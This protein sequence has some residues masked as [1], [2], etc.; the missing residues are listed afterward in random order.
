MTGSY[1]FNNTGNIQSSATQR[2]NFF[3]GD[4]VQFYDEGS[5]QTSNNFNHRFSA[6][7]EYAIDS[8]NSLILSPRLS[9]QDNRSGSIL[10]AITSLS[11][12]ALLNQAENDFRSDNRG[13]SFANELLFRHQFGKTGRTFSVAVNT[14]FSDRNGGN[15]LRAENQFF[16]PDSLLIVDQQ[17]ATVSGSYTLAA[18]LTYTEPLGR[19]SLLEF[20]YNPSYSRSRSGRETEAFDEFTGDY[21]D[22][23]PLL[24]NRFENTILNQRVGLSYRLRRTK[25][26]FSLGLNYQY[27]QLLSDQTFP[28]LLEVRQPFSNLLPMGMFSYRF[29]R[30]KTLRLFYRAFTSTP[31]INQLQ[32]VI[33]NSNPLLLRAGNPD[34]KQ[35]YTQNLT[36]RYGASNAEKARNW[37][38]FA[39]VS[40]TDQYIANSTFIAQADTVLTEGITLFSG[41]QLSRPV[42]LEGAWQV[43]S[44][45]SCGLPATLLKSNLNLNAGVVYGRTPG[46]I[47]GV[48]NEAST[49][50]FNSGIVLS[51]NISEKIDFRVSYAASYNIV[52]NSVNA[53]LNNNYY[54]GTASARINW[55][56]GKHWVLRSD[57]SHTSFRGLGTGFNQD[58]L[59]WNAGIGYRFLKGSAAEIQLR[60]FDLLNQNTS[61]S[62][63]VTETYLEDNQTQVLQRYLMLTFMY[64]LRNFVGQGK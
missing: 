3:S 58:F 21:T 55:L 43:R 45:L 7:L 38:L 16:A 11:G 57:A 20:N 18:R 27:L 35:Q 12:N 32:N 36:L 42:N 15:L 29:S 63:V 25:Y 54:S 53:R 23:Y 60:V 8:S 34:L 24:S 6:R 56:Y 64:N 49:Y 2:Q 5:R 44:F 40:Y 50:N 62:R 19:R 61:I 13:Y 37:F 9:L 47:N 51:S 22:L 46:L 41:S 59:L 31:S 48:V 39:N 4:N 1:F 33:D 17:T 10:S 26:N 28:R 14:D 30:E 52:D